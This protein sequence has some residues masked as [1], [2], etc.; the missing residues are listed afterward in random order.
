MAAAEHFRILVTG[1][2][3]ERDELVNERLQRQTFHIYIYICHLFA[4]PLAAT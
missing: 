3:I 1:S 2:A 4:A